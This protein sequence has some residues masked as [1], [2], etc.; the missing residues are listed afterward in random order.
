MIKPLP[1]VGDWYKD[2]ERG[3]LFE[4]VAFDEAERAVEI[5]YVDGAIE[6]FEL[7]S[8]AQMVLEAAAP[9]E[10]WRTGYELS[11]EDYVDPNDVYCPED[12]SGALTRVEPDQVGGLD[13]IW[14]E[15]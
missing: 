7:D 15:M 11:E 4:V 5:Q 10:D 14:A 1:N 2:L 9:P 8:W 12:L 13:D 3:L 6:E